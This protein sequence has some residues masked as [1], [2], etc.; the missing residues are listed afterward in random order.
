[1]KK[2]NKKAIASVALALGLI[3]PQAVPTISYADVVSQDVVKLRILETSD[4]HTNIL[5]YN[6]FTDKQDNTLG[7]SKVATLI[8]K[9]REEEKN[10]LLFDNGD[11][12]Q[13]NPLGDYMAANL[14]DG[15]T[16]PAIKAL[17]FLKYDASTLG[18]HEF[19][20]GLDYLNETYDDAKFDV[21]NAN[22][23]HD[24]KDSDPTN[25][26]NYFTPYKIQEKQ[27]VDA[28]GQSHTI[29]VGVIGF[30]P[31][32]ILKWD[33]DKLTGKVV[34]KDII[35]SANDFIPKMKA[36]GADVIVVLSHSGISTAA[37]EEGMENA[38]YYLTQ[39][40]GID[41]VLTGHNHLNFPALPGAAKQDFKDGNGF[42]NAK[43]T[44]N[45]VPVTMPGSYGNNLGVI[46][47]T[48]EKADGKWT[49][50]NSQ[51]TLRPIYDSVAKKSLVDAD[52]AL[53]EELKAEHEATLAYVRGPVGE[54]TAPINSYFAL[55]QDDPSIQIVT[56]AQK[57]YVEK[58]L[59]G[60][61]NANLPILSAGAPFKAGGRGG[62]GA[63]T[64]I[65]KGTIAIKNVADLY[66][67]P[68]TVY[69]VK[70]NG[71]DL[72]NWLEWSAG[73][74]KQVDPKKSEVQDLVNSSFPT[75]NFDVIDGVTYE[76]DVT[77]PNKY[78]NDQN[79]VNPEASRIINLKYDG[80]PVT[81]N[82]EFIV[83]TNN[84]RANGLLLAK[85]KKIVLASPDENRQ[86]I[87]DY[88]AL[89]KTI[90]PTAD[91]NWKFAPI[92]GNEGVKVSFES[93]PEAQK[94]VAEGSGVSYVSTLES[95][96]AKF[97]LSLPSLKEENKPEPKPENK[98][99]IW[100]GKQL[101]KGQIGQVTVSKDLNLWKR[102]G[103]KL[104]FVRVLKAGEEY[105]VYSYDSKHG[106][107]YGVG[108]GH[109]ITNVKGHVKYETPSKDKLKQANN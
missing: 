27:V 71:E 23:Y 95:G 79:L 50:K 100:K 41:A 10:T 56:N 2:T 97:E 82:Q 21:V 45:G 53:A 68:N 13:G 91:N 98:P 88:I 4:I 20:Y 3:I 25:D 90:N 96:F 30:V 43:G 61:E 39:I 33:R 62:V 60:T 19:N 105:R 107:Q 1:M 58:A 99:V 74:F 63:Y 26:K 109:Y 47:L 8:K 44:I 37:Y 29:K 6:Y 22:V 15:Q 14:K 12:I 84:Y 31:P 89:S 78:D 101:K 32:D 34:V 94:Y 59:K 86:A 24:D 85:S 104:V 81:P 66:L 18:N 51:A 52:P 17:N 72:K 28:D 36:D 65:A 75:Y 103:N 80:K 106:G 48:I 108:A 16:H 76:I 69:A 73:Q 35:K 11:L 92:K 64:D 46:D 42:D 55:I 57:W 87:I 93:S 102:E 77:Q 49:V 7:L 70:V 9:A 5:D 67:Y 54:T 40:K 38:T 83:A